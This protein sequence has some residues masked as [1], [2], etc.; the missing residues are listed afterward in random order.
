[1]CNTSSPQP[2]FYLPEPSPTT[3]YNMNNLTKPHLNTSSPCPN[4]TPSN[5]RNNLKNNISGLKELY[6]WRSGKF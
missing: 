5:N 4:P 2:I 6:A 1:M 3:N